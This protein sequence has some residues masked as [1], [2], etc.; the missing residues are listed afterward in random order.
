MTFIGVAV[1]VVAVQSLNYLHL[2]EQRRGWSA[3][4]CDDIQYSSTPSHVILIKKYRL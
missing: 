2:Q 1:C 4:V 3:F